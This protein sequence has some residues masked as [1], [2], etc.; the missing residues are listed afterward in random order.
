VT[1]CVNCGDAIMWMNT[2]DAWIHANTGQKSCLIHRKARLVKMSGRR[3][4]L[5]APLRRPASKRRCRPY[6]EQ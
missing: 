5:A 4:L 6:M 2:L 3:D 1:L